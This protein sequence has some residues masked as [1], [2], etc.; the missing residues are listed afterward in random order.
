VTERALWKGLTDRV[1]GV[2]ITNTVAYIGSLS[3]HTR[4]LR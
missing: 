4:E 1:I 2:E 3:L